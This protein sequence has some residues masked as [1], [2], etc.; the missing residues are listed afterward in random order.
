MEEQRT[1]QQRNTIEWFRPSLLALAEGQYWSDLSYLLR[2]LLQPPPSIHQSS[3]GRKKPAKVLPSTVTN[4]SNSN[5][6]S[7]RGSKLKATGGSSSNAVQWSELEANQTIPTSSSASINSQQQQQKEYDMYYLDYDL[8]RSILVALEKHGI[9]PNLWINLRHPSPVEEDVLDVL[10]LLESSI[11]RFFDVDTATANNNNNNSNNNNN[12][13]KKN[14]N[15]SKKNSSNNNNSPTASPKQTNA[16]TTTALPDNN[17]NKSSSSANQNNN[18]NNNNDNDVPIFGLKE[19]IEVVLRLDDYRYDPNSPHRRMNDDDDTD[20]DDDDSDDDDDDDEDEDDS[21]DYDSFA[22]TLHDLEVLLNSQD[23]DDDDNDDDDD[24]DSER[25]KSQR[26]HTSNIVS[27]ASLLLDPSWQG[28]GG[29][30]HRPLNTTK[31]LPR[32]LEVR[33][34]RSGEF[35]ILEVSGLGA[36]NALDSSSIERQSSSSSSSIKQARR[37]NDTSNGRSYDESDFLY[38]RKEKEGYLDA[39]PDVTHQLYEH[40]GNRKVR[41]STSIEY[42][43]YQQFQNPLAGS[44]YEIDSDDDDE[45]DGDDQGV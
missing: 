22:K 19:A 18:N 5:S 8:T 10:F 39:I 32:D 3:V 11:W 17:N 30:K 41:Y 31:R 28:G 9:L 33:V 25:N 43:L 42:D 40:N 7:R 36:N 37:D 26:R 6:N 44:F 27:L 20:D 24:D 34:T 16:S 23:G 13:K 1:Q 29:G 15:H 35:H 14:S 45:E 38:T 21:T 4:S 2:Y 12:D